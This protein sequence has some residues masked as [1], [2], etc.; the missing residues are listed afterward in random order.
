MLPNGDPVPL[1]MRWSVQIPHPA[2][3][4]RGHTQASDTT[5]LCGREINYNRWWTTNWPVT[6]LVCKRLAEESYRLYTEALARGE[7]FQTTDAF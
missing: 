6:C 2:G 7:E 4:N 5:T 1:D 3:R